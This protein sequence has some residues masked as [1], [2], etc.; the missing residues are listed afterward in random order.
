MTSDELRSL[1]SGEG[2]GLV[3]VDM[4]KAPEANLA[5]RGFAFLE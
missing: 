4:P 3:T 5:N 2:G 1:V